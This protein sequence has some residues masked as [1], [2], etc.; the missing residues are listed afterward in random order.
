MHRQLRPGRRSSARP[1]ALP[2]VALLI[3]LVAVVAAGCSGG[4]ATD[5]AARPVLVV[6]PVAGGVSASAFA[7]EV[8]AREESPLSFRVGGNLVERRVDVG[9]HVR[10]GDLLAVLDPGDLQAQA[11]AAQAQLVA[12]EAELARA[13]ADQ[14]R[15][16]KLGQGQLVSRSTIDAQNAAATAAQGQVNAARASLEVARNQAAYTQLRAPSNGVIASRSAEAGQVLGAGQAVF[17]LATDGAREIAFAVPEDAVAALK[18]GQPVLVESWSSQQRF[19]GR[20]RE[21]SPAADP[22]SR[23]YGARVVI[24]APAGSFEL[25]QSARVYLPHADNGGL[26]VPLA[27][28]QRAAAGDKPAVFVVDIATSTLALRPVELGPYGQER[29]PVKGGLTANDWVVAA[30]GHLLRVGQKVSPVDRDNKPVTP[31]S[32]KP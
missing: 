14:A 12:A 25:G 18:P 17:A 7:G 32:G 4:K 26:S 9:D 24:D 6:H 5:E 3:A 29:V 22:A 11:R 16:A 13:R 30:G 23:T 28:V 27:A 1:R 31:A 21:I 15:F 19:P 8:R 10:R 20:V 2:R